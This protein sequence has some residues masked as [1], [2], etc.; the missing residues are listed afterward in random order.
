MGLEVI[1]ATAALAG[2]LGSMGAQF[3]NRP[4]APDMPRQDPDSVD[5]DGLEQR[6][7]QKLKSGMSRQD[8]ILTS[9]LGQ[10]GGSKAPAK[11]KTILGY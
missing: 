10:V 2:S 5:P 1:L 3:L 11:Q 4:K 7:Q 6:K 9:P 8:T